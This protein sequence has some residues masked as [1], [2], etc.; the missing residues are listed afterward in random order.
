MFGAQV[1]HLVRGFT[2]D[3]NINEPLAARPT[4]THI[5]KGVFLFVDQCVRLLAKVVPPNAVWSFGIVLGHV[6]QRFVV[7]RPSRARDEWY[8]LATRLARE[9]V[10]HAK[11]VLPKAG[12]IRAE[13]QGGR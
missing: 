2:A 6:E 4:D 5:E 10:L 13:R 9:Q 1:P 3:R 7:R 8:F 11:R 12:F